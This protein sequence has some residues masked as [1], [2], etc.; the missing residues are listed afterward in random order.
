VTLRAVFAGAKRTTTLQ[1][2]PPSIA[3]VTAS[4]SPVHGGQKL[5][6]AITLTGPAP[7]GGT[8]VA[9]ASS[10]PGIL[11]LPASV[12]IKAGATHATVT[13]TTDAVT[14]PRTVTA[15]A[16]L[17]GAKHVAISVRP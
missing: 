5:T 11:E 9:L 6:L 7:A 4:A 3:S 12:A 13:A 16:T 10:A 14:A 15:T 1:L 17:N 8:S 2:L